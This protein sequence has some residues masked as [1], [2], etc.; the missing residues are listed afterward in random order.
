MPVDSYSCFQ[1]VSVSV[2]SSVPCDDRHRRLRAVSIEWSQK[3]INTR[4]AVEALVLHVRG[5]RARQNIP[6]GP[7]VRSQK[8]SI[9]AQIAP[10]METGSCANSSCQFVSG[11][12]RTTDR[13]APLR[14]LVRRSQARPAITACGR[15]S[16]N[17]QTSD[18][19]SF[20]V[21]LLRYP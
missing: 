7:P 20:R 15:N 11:F 16:T 18:T 2:C 10:V 19:R 1:T 21:L 12:S 5:P 9:G 13:L 3:H 8:G 17:G 4:N 6:Q 14:P